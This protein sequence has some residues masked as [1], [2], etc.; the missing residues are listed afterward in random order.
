MFSKAQKKA[1][2]SRELYCTEC[3][4]VKR[5]SNRS[6]PAETVGSILLGSLG[7]GWGAPLYQ[8]FND[9]E[10]AL[11]AATRA[12]HLHHGC[13]AAQTGLWGSKPSRRFG[14]LEA[15][16]GGRAVGERRG[17]P[18]KS[19][20]A[21][22]PQEHVAA[23]PAFLGGRQRQ[24]P[25]LGSGHRRTTPPPR[26]A[27]GAQGLRSCRPADRQ[28][29]RDTHTYPSVLA[30]ML[31]QI[32]IGVHAAHFHHQHKD[33]FRKYVTNPAFTKL[34]AKC[35]MDFKAEGIL[36]HILVAVYTST[37]IKETY[38]N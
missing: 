31:T 19:L 20:A 1:N 10:L 6:S 3:G 12:Q 24:D 37:L 25:G 23:A 29:T 18:G 22:G 16:G 17:S 13:A 35:F 28:L 34:L 21:V 27:L 7:P 38:E 36:C 5:A 33:A 4:S 9:A 30:E 14:G 2:Q 8:K 32:T 11:P 15:A 26:L